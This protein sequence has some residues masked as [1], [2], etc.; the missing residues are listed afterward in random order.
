MKKFI[1]R[2]L[3]VVLGLSVSLVLFVAIAFRVANRTNGT[4]VSA[5]EERSYLLHV[6]EGYDPSMP[7]PLVITIHGFAQWPAHQMR[8]THWN[9]LADEYGFIAVYPAGTGFPLR[10]RTVDG[11]DP[12]DDPLQDVNST[13]VFIHQMHG[14]TATIS[15]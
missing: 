1:V 7:V 14:M 6:P 15:P 9:D 8:I 3:W 12:A 13:S 2:L 5:G 10:W 4:I 11:P